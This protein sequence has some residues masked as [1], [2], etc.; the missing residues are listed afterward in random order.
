MASASL[1]QALGEVPAD[2]RARWHD[3]FVKF[4]V[5]QTGWIDANDLAQVMGNLR[6]APAPGE[7]EA[8]IQAV[9]L[10][11]DSV[12]SV[13]EFE[14]M[15]VA[16]G[17]G[18]S[19]KNVGFSHV[20]H[21]HI[22]MAEVARLICTECR[23]FVDRFCRLNV[24]SYMELP[25]P[26]MHPS[27]VEQLPLWHDTHRRFVEEAELMVQNLMV[28][29]GVASQ[30]QFQDEFLDAAMEGGML[31]D[32]LTLADYGPFVH[33]MQAYVEQERSGVPV[34]DGSVAASLPRPTTPHSRNKT[35]QR[36]AELD[37]E[38]AMMDMKRNE[39]LAERRR[40]I[41]CEV[42]P[43]TTLALRRELEMRRW[44]EDVGLD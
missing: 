7:V 21:R 24:N 23:S 16:A 10:D 33:T 42:E 39:L 11:E 1:M 6:M 20:V 8:M 28:L 14:L 34:D 29:W 26:D 38:L 44:R 12:I 36:I 41:G 9:D 37:R 35:Q 2:L 22:K 5:S 30:Q 40:L 17:R 18:H 25:T 31:D 3:A 15:M 27:S 13:Q 43:V 4:D 32:F 19:D